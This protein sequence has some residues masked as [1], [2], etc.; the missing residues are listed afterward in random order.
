MKN[1]RL[2]LQLQVDATLLSQTHSSNNM[3]FSLHLVLFFPYFLLCSATK[4][5]FAGCHKVTGS[6][7]GGC[8]FHPNTTLSPSQQISAAATITHF[9]VLFNSNCSPHSRILVCSTFAPFC[10]LDFSV[11]PCRQLCLVVKSSCIHLF[12]LY[13]IQW[14]AALNCS[15]FP[16]P[17]QICVSPPLSSPSSPSTTPSLKSTNQISTLSFSS[18]SPL[19]TSS[20]DQSTSIIT[21]ASAL[22]S[23]HKILVGLSVAFGSLVLVLFCILVCYLCSRYF[24]RKTPPQRTAASV[25]FTAAEQPAHLPPS[26]PPPHEAPLTTESPPSS[27]P[28]PLPPKQRDIHVY[29]IND[30]I[31]FLFL[32]LFCCSC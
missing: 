21:T 11:Q 3:M 24:R 6:L 26:S 32:F 18:S 13:N 25:V 29:D 22:P 12:I 4:T 19:P 23:S 20:S 17:P 1:E 27:P 28:P 8:P 2:I 30:I 16:S 31:I 15:S 9:D 10:F 5:N 7:K 14:P